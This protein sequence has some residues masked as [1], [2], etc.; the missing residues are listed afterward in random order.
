MIMC[1]N[2]LGCYKYGNWGQKFKSI[3]DKYSI[4]MDDDANMV[5]LHHRGRHATEYHS[6]I[7]DLLQDFEEIA[8]TNSDIFKNLLI[9]L[10][11]YLIDHNDLLYPSGWGR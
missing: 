9:G 4:P 1:N 2:L 8:G 7:W 3:F 11:E 10:G 6:Y 5:T